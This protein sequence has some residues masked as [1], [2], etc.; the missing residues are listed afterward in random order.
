MCRFTVFS[1]FQLEYY[2]ISF[3][4]SLGWQ[5]AAS[6]CYG[7]LWTSR[8]EAGAFGPSWAVK[9]WWKSLKS[10]A[11]WRMMQGEKMCTWGSTCLSRPLWWILQACIPICCNKYSW[12]GMPRVFVLACKIIYSVLRILQACIILCCNIYSS[13]GMPSRVFVLACRIIYSVLWILQACILLCCNIYSW[14][15]MPRVFVLVCKII[16]TLYSEYCKHVF[17]S[18]AIYIPHWGCLEYLFLSVR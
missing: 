5:S 10:C 7:R 16:Y 2:L 4:Q 15:R 13:L 6:L 9:I 17:S 1:Y 11:F 12:L 8:A 18:V 3:S 14:F